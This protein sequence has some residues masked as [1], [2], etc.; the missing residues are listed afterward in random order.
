MIVEPSFFPRPRAVAPSGLRLAAVHVTHVYRHPKWLSCIFM[1]LYKTVMM[2]T[3]RAQEIQL[4]F[5]IYNI[6]NGGSLHNNVSKKKQN[7]YY[8]INIYLLAVGATCFDPHV[9]SSSG[10]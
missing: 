8:Y 4:N 6:Y 9:G 3:C 10:V 7:R 5:T 1:C 2:I